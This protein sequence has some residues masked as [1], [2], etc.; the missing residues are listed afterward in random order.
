[1]H[2]TAHGNADSHIRKCFFW[3]WFSLYNKWKKKKQVTNSVCLQTMLHAC[4]CR[5]KCLKENAAKYLQWLSKN[6]GIF[7][8]F[9]F[10]VLLF[11][12]FNTINMVFLW[13]KKNKADSI[14]SNIKQWHSS[15][16]LYKHPFSGDSRNPRIQ[17]T[18]T[19]PKKQRWRRHSLPSWN[20]WSRGARQLNRQLKKK[21]VKYYYKGIKYH[22]NSG[23]QV[24]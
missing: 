15:F 3:H 16:R 17:P 7:G 2:C 13:N 9:N 21:R 4:I 18:V 24:S 22:E 11:Y 1:M 19:V 14:R 5:R 23:E 12:N 6:G 20:S 10:T 8:D